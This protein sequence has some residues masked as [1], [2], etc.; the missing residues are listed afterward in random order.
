MGVCPAIIETGC[1]DVAA[2]SGN[3]LGKELLP[4]LVAYCR[5][6]FPGRELVRQAP[7]LPRPKNPAE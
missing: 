1:A 4:Q 5:R 2:C 7:P 3:I 6:D